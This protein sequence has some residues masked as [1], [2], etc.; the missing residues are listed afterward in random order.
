MR[1][2]HIE[3]GRISAANQKNGAAASHP[4][5]RRS[6]RR[7]GPRSHVSATPTDT[8]E[9]M[10]RAKASL[11]QSELTRYCEGRCARRASTTV[12]MVIEK[13]DGT[14]VS[15]SSRAR[16]RSAPLMRPTEITSRI[17][18]RRCTRPMRRRK[19]PVQGRLHRARIATASCG[20]GCGARSRT[21][22]STATCNGT[23]RLARIPRKPTRKR[24]RARASNDAVDEARHR[25]PILI[26]N[27]LAV[28]CAYRNLSPMATRQRQGTAAR[29]DTGKSSAKPGTPQIKPQPRRGS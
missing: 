10:P 27:Y 2:R 1:R 23:L 3:G 7:P 15:A 18:L 25:S 24:S 5:P 14:K 20:T 17:S 11:S 22:P 21:A 26:A 12:R 29:L 4:D 13:P 16:P 19:N 8:G 28:D 6:C 9:T